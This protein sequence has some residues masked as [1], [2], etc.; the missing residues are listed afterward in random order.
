MNNKIAGRI[1]SLKRHLKFNLKYPEIYIMNSNYLRS[2]YGTRA[3]GFLS[4]ITFRHYSSDDYTV[5]K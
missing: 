2:E 5:N 4:N 1:E 3:N